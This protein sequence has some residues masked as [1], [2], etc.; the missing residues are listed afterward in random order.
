MEKPHFFK[1]WPG[2]N[3]WG[4]L[5]VF[6]V[7]PYFFLQVVAIERSF[8]IDFAIL[9]LTIFQNWNQSA[10]SCAIG[11]GW[12]LGAMTIKL[13]L[14]GRREIAP[15]FHGCIFAVSSSTSQQSNKKKVTQPPSSSHTPL[16]N[17]LEF[18]CFSPMQWLSC[19]YLNIPANTSFLRNFLLYLL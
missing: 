11:Q 19:S 12:T 17:F 13:V 8:Y 3:W 5:R 16:P 6:Y 10:S 9:A 14:V 15:T 1:F 2:S 18:C 7:Q 4:R